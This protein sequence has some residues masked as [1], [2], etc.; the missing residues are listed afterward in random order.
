MNTARVL[1][2]AMLRRYVAE[3]IGAFGLLF[4][5]CGVRDWVG[6]VP[7]TDPAGV[8]VV[9]LAFGFA[10]AVAIYSLTHISSAHFNPAITFGFALSRHF[11]WKYVVPYW[12]AQFCGAILAIA[13]HV[14]IL[15]E[16]AVA[17]H[18]GAT[19]PQ[20]GVVPALTIEIILTF[21]LM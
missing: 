21:F 7:V 14:L 5:G 8:L 9:H 13:L 2:T 6:D 18:F 1:S 16:K 10:I 12:I 19:K 17:A 11:R 15:P 3:C 20:G 4:F